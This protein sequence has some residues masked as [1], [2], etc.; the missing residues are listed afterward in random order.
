MAERKS[1]TLRKVEAL[2]NGPI[3]AANQEAAAVATAGTSADEATERAL[4][5]E[6][7]ALHV[8]E[9]SERAQRV[10]VGPGEI[11]AAINGAGLSRGDAEADKAEPAETSRLVDDQNSTAGS[12]DPPERRGLGGLLWRCWGRIWGS[13]AQCYGGRVA[14]NWLVITVLLTILS[15]LVISELEMEAAHVTHQQ[16]FEFLRQHIERYNV[17]DSDAQVRER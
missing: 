13:D 6:L 5:T 16:N 8:A 17:T 14:L 15:S 12:S 3:R 10:G 4:R 1:P 11:A 9:L 2:I 7:S